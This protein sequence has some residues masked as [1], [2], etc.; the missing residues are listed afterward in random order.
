LSR[1]IKA[2]GRRQSLIVSRK[3]GILE[4]IYSSCFDFVFFVWVSRN[5]I[6]ARKVF[7]ERHWQGV[8]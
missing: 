4:Y 3:F 2:G 6:E 5:K 7:E 1:P 8:S